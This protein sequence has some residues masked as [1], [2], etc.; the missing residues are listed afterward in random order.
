MKLI[1]PVEP[2]GKQRPRVVTRNGRVIAYTPGQTAM[3]EQLIR[4][5]LSQDKTYFERDIPISL[6]VTF[7]LVRPKSCPKKRILPVTRP[8]IDN[9]EKLVLDACNKFLWADD[10]QITTMMSRKRYGE[11]RIELE[12]IQD[13]K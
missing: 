3:T 5:Y 8:D 11:P 13:E 4:A 1:I 2:R 7:Y 6:K 10:S 12:V 9:L